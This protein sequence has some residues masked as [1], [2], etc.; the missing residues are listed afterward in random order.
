MTSDSQMPCTDAPEAHVADQDAATN[1][2]SAADV[3]TVDQQP[4]DASSAAAVAFKVL[5]SAMFAANIGHGPQQ[6]SVQDFSLSLLG[7]I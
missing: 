5:F 1:S 6:L 2:A 3:S 4:D 7:K